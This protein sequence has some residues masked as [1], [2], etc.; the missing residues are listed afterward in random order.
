MRKA[1]EAFLYSVILEE[2]TGAPL[3]VLSLLA[4]QDIDPWEEAARYSRMPV[5]AAAAKLSVLLVD[6][7]PHVPEDRVL[8]AAVVRLLARLPQPTYIV[9]ASGHP[10][11]PVLGRVLERLKQASRFWIRNDRR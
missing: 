5:D 10:L 11:R 8:R 7:V 6:H 1:F 3:T 9:A 4:R 2:E